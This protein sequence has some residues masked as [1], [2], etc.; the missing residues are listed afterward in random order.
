MNWNG[1]GSLAIHDGRKLWWGITHSEWK[2]NRDE[3]IPLISIGTDPDQEKIEGI[4]KIH[5]QTESVIAPSLLI[6][7][8]CYIV[9]LRWNEVLEEALAS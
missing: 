5:S 3:N 8:G 9:A 2:W 6:L 1:S 4:I 7:L